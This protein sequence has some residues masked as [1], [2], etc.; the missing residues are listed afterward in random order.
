MMKITNEKILE[1]REFLQINEKAAATV[2]KYIRDVRMFAVWLN[3]KTLTK[4][5]VLEY[6]EYLKKNYVIAS[7]NAAISSL[8]AFFDFLQMKSLCIKTVKVQKQLFIRTEKELTKKEYS[9]LLAAANQKGNIR[10]NL[11]MQTI[12]STGIRVSELH[13]ITVEALESE[14]AQIHSKGKVRRVFLP[15]ALCK[16]LLKYAASRNI[17]QGPVFVTKSGRPLNR[18]NIW[19]DMKKLCEVA[20]VPKE[21]VFPHNLR[22]LFARTFY[23]IQKDIVRL[24]DILG[25]SSV[26]TTRIYTMETGEIHRKKI[27]MLGLLRC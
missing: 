4:S 1:F 7:A 14:T 12:C 8:N 18:S 21:K 9:R 20:Q 3:G 5:N 26:N 25:H 23:S 22:H 19:S 10:L 15:K 16:T 27:Q 6:K 2:Q 13:G 11:V 17:K 24:A